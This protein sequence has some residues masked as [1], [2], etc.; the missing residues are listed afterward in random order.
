MP[1]TLTIHT[2]DVGQGDASLIVADNGPGGPRRAML[3]DGGHQRYGAIVMNY[4]TAAG[5]PGPARLPVDHFLASHYDTDHSSGIAALLTA[6]NLYALV[7]LL[8]GV[9]IVQDDDLAGAP[10]PR[11]VARMA[12]ATGTAA[13]GA[14]GAAANAANVAAA[15]AAVAVSAAAT[16]AQATGIGLYNIVGPN[17][18]PTLLWTSARRKQAATGA[19][20]GLV[21][22][23]AAGAVGAAALLPYVRDGIRQGIESGVMPGARMDTGGRFA[24]T[25]VLDIGAAGQ[26]PSNYVGG[27]AGILLL[28]G[29]QGTTV[30]GVNRMRTTVALGDEVLWNSGPNAMV[31]PAGAP[32]VFVVAAA[33]LVFQGN[34]PSIPVGG[35]SNG[36]SI[37]LLVRFNR[38]AFYTGGDLPSIGGEEPLMTYVMNNA[39]QVPGG[40]VYPIPPRVVAFKCGHH[41]AAPSTSGPM[42][43]TAQPRN[44]MVS[45]GENSFD[46]PTQAVITR[47]DG[48]GSIQRYYLTNCRLPRVGVPRSNVVWTAA[49]PGADQRAVPG[50]KSRVAGD[51]AVDNLANPR[52]RGDIVITA[53]QAG[54]VAVPSQYTVDYWEPFAAANFSQATNW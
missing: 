31:P 52:H 33:G 24:Q 3:V 46:H 43:A 25:H 48:A 10:A 34:A 40:A 18:Q 9:A 44:A 6:D 53:T 35:G 41:G 42:L 37:G 32:A 21:A 15:A 38:L 17:A 39:L 11:T 29:N 2:I 27:A 1:W 19:V 49:A 8:A 13:W 51:N 36:L 30:P 14:Y 54:T 12:A 50:N 5:A 23:R 16:T 4:L 28:G 47:L 20:N 7:D 22:G 45:S 26:P